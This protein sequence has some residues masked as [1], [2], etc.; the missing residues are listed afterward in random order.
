MDNNTYNLFINYF[1]INVFILPDFNLQFGD[2][3]LITVDF[4]LLDSMKFQ[5]YI[6]PFANFTAQTYFMPQSVNPGI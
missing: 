3:L 4:Y 1:L 2:S 6:W 5:S